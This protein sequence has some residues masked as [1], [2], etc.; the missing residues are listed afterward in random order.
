MK[1]IVY[2]AAALLIAVTGCKKEPKTSGEEKPVGKTPVTAISLSPTDLTLEIGEKV[3]ITATVTPADATDKSLSWAAAPNDIIKMLSGEGTS[4]EFEAL[5]AGNAS[6]A[7]YA[8]DGSGVKAECSV[9][10]KAKSAVPSGAV[11][12]G[13]TMKG[14]GGTTY[15]L[16]WADS[17]LG[18]TSPEGNGDYYAWGEVK[19]KTDY[20]WATYVWCKGASNKLTKYCPTNFQSYWDGSGS[21]DGKLVLD[22][23]DDAAHAKLGGN[24]RMPTL[25]EWQELGKCEKK[26]WTT[27]NGVKGVRIT[28][29]NGNSIF[30]PAAGFRKND[31]SAGGVGVVGY[32]WTSSLRYEDQPETAW[33]GM[34]KENEKQPLSTGSPERCYG[35]PVRP[36]Y[37]PA[38]E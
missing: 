24:W 9:T 31:E 5:S 6:I 23:E 30:L 36:V 2:L 12:L 32:Y 13:I 27:Q 10:V 15:K 4:K 28:G 11:D 8:L 29:N 14:S 26:V 18:A 34:I 20:S 22:L 21:P 1:R 38:A 19:P 35:Y 7:V 17:N 16:Y 25:K 37:Q 33:D 3:V